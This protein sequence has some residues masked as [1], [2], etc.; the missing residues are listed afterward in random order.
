MRNLKRALSLLLSSTMVLGMLVMGSSAASYTDVTSEE[1]V[2]AIEVLKAV[3]VMTGDENGNFNPNKQVTRAEMA[4]VMANLLDLKV[5]DFKGASLPFTDVPEWAV[6]YVAACY[7]DGITA[8]IS[9]TEYGSNNSVTTAQAALMMMKAL[10]Y[11]Q[12]AKDFGSD[13]QVATVKQGSKIDLF[14]GIEAGASTAMTRNDVAQ[15][16]LN[17]LESTMVETD[18]T[19]TTIT[20][21]GGITIDSGDTKY[22]E[23]TNAN[24]KYSVIDSAKN[25]DNYYVQLGEKLYDGKLKLNKDAA[26]SFGRPSDKWTYDGD[27]VGVYGNEADY[28]VVL[29]KDYS[30]KAANAND[31]LK[32]L[33]DLTNNDDLSLYQ[34]GPTD[35]VKLY[36]NGKDYSG[37]DY[38]AHAKAG[39]VLELFCDGNVIETV[40]GYNYKTVTVD[41]VDKI[42]SEEE[43]ADKYGASVT[44]TLKT[45]DGDMTYVD[46]LSKD[47]SGVQAIGS[48]DEGDVLAVVES[49][50]DSGKLLAVGTANSVNGKMTAKG[51]GYVKVDGTKYVSNMAAAN[52]DDTYTFYLDPKGSVIGVELYEEGDANLQ[53]VYVLKAQG[54]TEDGDLIDGKDNRAVVKVMYADGTTKVVDYALTKTGSDDYTSGY[55]FKVGSDKYDLSKFESTV[56]EG[57]YAYT[58]NS[59][60]EITLKSADKTDVSKVIASVDIEKDGRTLATGLY[61]TSSTKVVVL[62]EDGIA[63]TY[64][65]YANFPSTKVTDKALVVYGSSES[66]AKEVYIYDA[67]A[68]TDVAKIDVAL[69]VEKG[70]VTADGVVCTFYVDGKKVNYT[71]D[72][73]DTALSSAVAGQLFEIDVNDDNVATLSALTKDTDY[74]YG[75]VKAVSDDYVVVDSKDIDLAKD[76]AVYQVSSTN[77]TLTSASL[78]EGQKVVVFQNDDGAYLIFIYKNA[79]SVVTGG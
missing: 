29:D 16:T 67:D 37:Q 2:E 75:E 27:E 5:E 19:N 33:K 79:P 45:V 70:D 44:Y 43:L 57:W 11:F 31:F 13:W 76:C 65:G 60:N 18:G 28:V 53:Y 55:Y 10:G 30:S 63:N 23:V 56:T 62:N 32:V 15:L 17:T 66:Y 38:S 73:D 35:D 54:Q 48:Y 34:V 47:K 59:D 49:E 77:K 4:V 42:D 72:S 61:A 41:S 46:T 58:M 3:G 24:D 52:Y 12:L 20:L 14:D 71:V 9:A 22:V 40:V 7:A 21:P 25:G 26:D 8:G 64:T 6:P 68:K 69:F 1:N 39:T 74:T 78:D 51:D 36:I 50:K